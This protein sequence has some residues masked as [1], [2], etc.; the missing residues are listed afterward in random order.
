MK[1]A[2]ANDLS[3]LTE[4]EAAEYTRGAKKRRK[5]WKR[6]KE[7]EKSVSAEAQPNIIL[8]RPG[9]AKRT[10]LSFFREEITL[11]KKLQGS[12]IFS[13]CTG[14][15]TRDD[16]AALKK[17]FETEPGGKVSWNDVLSAI[18]KVCRTLKANQVHEFLNSF[19]PTGK[20]DDEPFFITR[21]NLPFIPD[22][23]FAQKY[24]HRFTY[25]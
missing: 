18:P 1:L 2:R 3:R 9:E 12:T 17:L 14:F 7:E 10:T 22:K 24:S 25:Y 19:I 4:L 6:L 21:V 15:I 8:T 5:F 20:T 13:E 23:W 16:W 11:P